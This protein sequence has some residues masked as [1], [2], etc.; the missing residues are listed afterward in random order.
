M[1]MKELASYFIGCLKYNKGNFIY[2]TARFKIINLDFTLY[3]SYKIT[4]L[5]KKT[6]LIIFAPEE[7]EIFKDYLFILDCLYFLM[8]WRQFLFSDVKFAI[9][10]NKNR[11]NQHLCLN[12]QKIKTMQTKITI[13]YLRVFRDSFKIYIFFKYVFYMKYIVKKKIEG[14]LI[15]LI[16]IKKSKYNFKK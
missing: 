10:Q 12:H 5:K 16:E 9:N 8:I 3:I 1:C 15:I 11:K 6:I 13:R 7:A 14:D 2:I 4:F